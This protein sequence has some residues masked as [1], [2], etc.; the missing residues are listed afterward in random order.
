M[1]HDCT[2]KLHQRFCDIL[3]HIIPL[4]AAGY[5][6]ERSA[7]GF[8]GVSFFLSFF[9]WEIGQ[10]LLLWHR[11]SRSMNE[12]IRS[13]VSPTWQRERRVHLI[14]SSFNFIN[15]RINSAHGCDTGR[16]GGRGRKPHLSDNVWGQRESEER[17]KV[18]KTSIC[19]LG[20]TDMTFVSFIP[21]QSIKTYNG[22]R[23]DAKYQLK[24]L[25]EIPTITCKMCFCFHALCKSSAILSVYTAS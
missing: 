17:Q 20:C 5:G 4:N 15:V 8:C 3:A 22:V 10:K 18:K 23:A 24:C 13:D 16:E 1:L 9:C 2:C 12:G 11:L 19:P 14:R 6:A 7:V 21:W 25:F